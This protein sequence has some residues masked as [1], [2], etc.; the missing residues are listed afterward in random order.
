MLSAE[1][2]AGYGDE[3]Y[4]AFVDRKP[5]VPLTEREPAIDI[6]DGYAIQSR[7]IARRVAAKIECG[8]TWVNSWFLRDLRTPFGGSKQS[9]IGREGGVHSLEFYSELRNVCVKL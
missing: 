5:V 8:I 6:A 2:N 1:K 9:G 3:L 4:L 7:F